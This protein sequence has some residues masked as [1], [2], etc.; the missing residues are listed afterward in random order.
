[1]SPSK[2]IQSID[3]LRGLCVILM[4]IH[5]LLYDI[6]AYLGA[7]WEI[8]SN[9][10]FDV[11]HYIFAGTFILLAGVSSRFSRSNLKRGVKVLVCAAVISLVT[12]LMKTPILFGILHFMGIAMVFY[13]LSGKLW[14]K[15]PGP[16]LPIICIILTAVTAR[17][18]G[19]AV[20]SS[21]WLWPLG[22]VYPGF[23]SADYFPLL[24]WI[25]VFLAGTWLGEKIKN[26]SFPRW[27]YT[28]SPP[29]LPKI[30]RRA[31]IIYMLHQPV[32]YGLTLLTGKILGII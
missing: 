22:F 19:G 27:F 32:L 13:A 7:P 14:E 9:P 17:L 23:F 8:F 29:L 6:A 1:M 18:A 30:G 2:R 4:C 12:W 26:G 24:P 16:T 5:H 28:V 25:F 15:L 11:L 31:L 20:V 21:R 3:A 10:V